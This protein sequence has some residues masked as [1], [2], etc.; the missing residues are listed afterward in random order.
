MCERRRNQQ[1]TNG[2]KDPGQGRYHSE[3]K[4]NIEVEVAVLLINGSVVTPISV[5][6]L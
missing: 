4:F 3:L 5:V 1:N 2:H 6:F